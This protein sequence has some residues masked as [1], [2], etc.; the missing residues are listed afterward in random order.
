MDKTMNLILD[1]AAWASLLTLTALEIILG[2]DN[3][4]VLS[5]L[6]HSLPAREAR[7]ARSVGLSLALILRLLLLWAISWIKRLT[8]PVLSIYEQVFSWRDLILIGGGLFLMLK[9]TQE[10]HS[11]IE[12]SD[13]AG[14]GGP[15]RKARFGAVIAQIAAT[16]LIFSLDSIVTAVGLARDIEVM[17]AAICIAVAIMYFAAEPVGAFISRHPTTKMLALC[18]LMLIGVALVADG[19]GLHIPRGYIYFAMAFASLVE[20]FNVWMRSRRR[21]KTGR[22]R[23]LGTEVKS[24]PARHDERAQDGRKSQ[25]ADAQMRK[26]SPGKRKRRK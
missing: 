10:I 11:E 17:A 25:A 23:H 26:T 22:D 13:Q 3:I 19:F 9:A 12:G 21:Y 7:R 5:I 14:S 20:T 1:P 6:T 24:A 15:G 4:V 8:Y 18:F 2:V 16:D